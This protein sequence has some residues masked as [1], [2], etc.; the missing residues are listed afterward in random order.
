MA[1]VSKRRGRY[2]L[3]FYDNHGKRQRQTLAKGTTL[4]KAKEKLREIEDRLENGALFIVFAVPKIPL[5][6]FSHQYIEFIPE[7]APIMS[8]SESPSISTACTEQ[9]PER[10]MESEIFVNVKSLLFFHKANSRDPAPIISI[11]P[12]LSM[13]QA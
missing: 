3:D 2:V 12:S 1:K 10:P 6:V 11:S 9:P 4:K 8:R 13:S 7:A 5:P